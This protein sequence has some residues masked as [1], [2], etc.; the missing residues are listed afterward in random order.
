MDLDKAKSLLAEAGFPDG[1]SATLKL[2]PPTYAR[3]G[4][5]VIAAQLARIGIELEIIPVEWAQWLEQVFRGDDFDLTI[6]SHT[7]PLDIG[8]YDREDYYFNYSSPAFA[9][10]LAQLKGTA[11]QDARYALLADAQRILAEDAV[12]GYIFQLPKIGIWRSGLSGF[13]SNSPIQANDVT[14]VRWN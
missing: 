12:N 14:G 2:P 1:F 13:W 6:V 3:R 8:I 5:E 9:D 4:G 10:V 11:D 7:E